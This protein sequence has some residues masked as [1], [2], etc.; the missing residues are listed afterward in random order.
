MPTRDLSVQWTIALGSELVW[1]DK[2]SDHIPII[3]AVEN[4]EG[5]LGNERET[6]REDLCDQVEMQEK[7]I[8]ILRETYSGNNRSNARNWTTAYDKIA[9]LLSE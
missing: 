7:I 5:E 4:T 6:I 1:K 2:P 9:K 3:L 8:Q